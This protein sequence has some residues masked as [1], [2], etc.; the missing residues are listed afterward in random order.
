MNADT[1]CEEWVT[2]TDEHEIL[3]YTD[4]IQDYCSVLIFVIHLFK[5]SNVS[6]YL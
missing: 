3:I 1:T 4:K 6:F 2:Q 5:V